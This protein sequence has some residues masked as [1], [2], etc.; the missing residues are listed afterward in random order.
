MEGF[1]SFY[2]NKVVF[3]CILF[4]IYLSSCNS[5]HSIP[6][7]TKNDTTLLTTSQKNES[8]KTLLNQ[9]SRTP[10]ALPTNP[11]P[12]PDESIPLSKDGPWLV[13]L[14]E[15]GLWAVNSDGSSLQNIVEA[16]SENYKTLGSSFSTLPFEASPNGQWLA[17]SSTVMEGPEI[18]QEQTLYLLS[19][20]DLGL[21]KVTSLYSD[22]S[23]LQVR[24]LP[25]SFDPVPTEEEEYVFGEKSR[26]IRGAITLEDSLA[27]SSD[28]GQLAFSAALDGPSTDV[29]VLDIESSTILRV[30]DG[31]KTQAVNLTWT[32][33]DKYIIHTASGDLNAGR[34]G[35]EFDDNELWAADPTGLDT[36]LVAKRLRSIIRW[37]NNEEFLG[38][39]SELLS[40][41]GYNQF[42]YNLS[43]LNARTSEEKLLWKDPFISADVDPISK[44][45]IVDPVVVGMYYL[46]APK[47]S[48]VLIVN[49]EKQSIE[50]STP[51]YWLKQRERF[52]GFSGDKMVMLTPAGDISDII[53]NPEWKYKDIADNISF[54][55]SEKDWA[56]IT[57]PNGS[58]GIW[59][60]QDGVGIKEILSE[61]FCNAIWRPDGKAIFFY[62][63]SFWKDQNLIEG[64]IYIAEAPEF[65][66]RLIKTGLSLNCF[67]DPQW[68]NK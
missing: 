23:K 53:T 32:P 11:L 25:S 6:P 67:I 37:I 63:D 17:Y 51:I 16:P 35:P 59:I 41:Y 54:S 10:T 13:F 18:N 21:K 66:P 57:Y 40:E 39:E 56:L 68:V 38:Y 3:I 29:Y 27:W 34:S 58:G 22:E 55:P 28:G 36:H 20:P 60:Y 42:N 64:S 49:S 12:T 65:R 9:I 7:I 26:Q 48:P 46:A 45:V 8:S 15:T 52:A 19:F 2:H 5:Y 61:E 43:I 62:S 1:S 24:E 31:P 47:Y 14:G 44:T 4:F 33:D 50:Y 30:T